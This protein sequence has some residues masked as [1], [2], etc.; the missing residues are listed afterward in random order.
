MKI[1]SFNV[2]DVNKRLGNLIRWLRA[3]KP[4]V[5]APQELKAA[6]REFPKAAIAKAGYGAVWRGQKTRN[7]VAILARGCEPIVTRREL[8][9]DPDDRQARYIEAAVNGV[10]VTSL[11]APNGNPRPGPKFDYKLAWMD[12]L[13]AHAKELYA[14]GV[15]VVLAGDYNVVPT[16]RDIYAVRSYAEDALLQPAP[17]A[18]FQKLLR[19]GWRD[20]LRALHPDA[21]LYTYWSYLRNRWPRDAG[22]RIDHLLLSALAAKRLAAAGV[23]REVRGEVGASDHAPAWVEL[24][25]ARGGRS[26]PRE[27]GPG[28]DSRSLL[29]PSREKELSKARSER[30]PLLVIDGDSFAHRSYHALPK[31]IHRDGGRPAG[32]ILGFANR[33]LQLYRTERPRAVLVGW[34]TLEAETY[35]HKAFPAYQSGRDFD[36]DLVEQLELIPKFVAACGFA[37]ERRAGY[38]ADDFLAAATVAEERRGGTVLVAS[39]DRDTFQLA[40][41]RT[42]I[43]YPVKAGEMAR[44][45]PKEVR[46]R[47][48]VAPKQ[49]P[50]FIALRGDPSDQLP[51]APGIGAQGA[52]ALIRKYGSLAALLKAGRFAKQAEDLKLYRTI[53][54][55]D[56]KAPLP[57]IAAQTPTWH[58]AAAL[59]RKWQLNKLAVRLEEMAR[60]AVPPPWEEVAAD[61]VRTR[62]FGRPPIIV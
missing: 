2:N 16:D 26:S 25:Q 4:D 53:A 56:Q 9:G 6:D 19:Q 30:R 3:E 58:K 12:R 22:L 35:R 7:G 32:A 1:A 54:T 38:E 33:L 60:K 17:R 28:A 10:I 52:A 15:P 36:D 27:G 21:A 45:G 18:Q 47:Y 29:A 51:G 46:E 43:L 44:I 5:V 23:D 37:N 49:V 13:L 59:A 62:P 50:D 61:V 57:K 42:T 41:E 20:A 11:Y 14:A 48:G 55:M 40:S 24:R 34:D 8:P 31:T 39:G